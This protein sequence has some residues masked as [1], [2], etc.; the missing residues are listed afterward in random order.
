MVGCR[1]NSK[2]TLLKNYL[3]LAEKLGVRIIPETQAIDCWPIE[4]DPDQEHLY[5]ISCQRSTGLGKGRTYR[6]KS[7]NVIFAGGV[8][9]TLKL[10]FHCRD[11]SG[12]LARISGR[13]GEKVRTNSEALLG[14]VSDRPETDHTWGI[15]IGSVFQADERTHVETFRFPRG[16]SFLYRLLGS[17]LLNSGS[18]IRKRW[19]ELL[20]YSARNPIRFLD[21]KLNP[22][23][24]Q[25]VAPL[26]V[27][28][29]EDNLMELRP[30]KRRIPLLHSGLTSVRDE[31]KPIEAEIPIAH[32]VT[33]LFANEIEG[34]PLGNIVESLF[35]V[36][37]TA[38]ILGGCS[39]GAIDQE[40][41]VDQF[42]RVFNYPGPVRPV[43]VSVLQER[44]GTG[45]A[46]PRRCP[47]A[48]RLSLAQI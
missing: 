38:H 30:A 33:R 19:L 20:R 18:N 1:Y 28:Q 44:Y 3:Y 24:G 31:Q 37:I 4:R 7:K 46:N 11:V 8:L 40:G 12:G 36:P 32:K 13:L 41:V 2:N 5:Q 22:A 27:M 17:P 21:A 26:L 9:G 15:A 42:G 6:I 35:N 48:S 14:A 39:F 16:S 25:R 23:W 29:T 34:E 43:Y 47:G 45:H 10:L